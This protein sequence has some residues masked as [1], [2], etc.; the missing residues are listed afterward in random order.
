MDRVGVIVCGGQSRRMGADKNFIRWGNR[1]L[2]QQVVDTLGNACDQLVLVAATSTQ[3]L[4]ELQC[5]VPLQRLE[6][7][8]SLI[9][10]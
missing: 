9:H 7:D 4:P 3:T 2:L 5:S 8:L 10:I 6:D 1:T